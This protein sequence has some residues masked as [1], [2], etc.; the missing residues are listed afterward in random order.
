MGRDN[1]GAGLTTLLVSGP[2]QDGDTPFGFTKAGDGHLILAGDNTYGG[3]TRITDGTVL[4]R[5]SNAFGS[6]TGGTLVEGPA[7]IELDGD[8]AVPEPLTLANNAPD[9]AVRALVGTNTWS[10]PVTSS[11]ASPLRALNTSSLTFTGGVTAPSG[12]TLVPDPNAEI[13]ISGAPLTA[14]ASSKI[15]AQG[16]GTVAFGASD[17][18][19]G[20]LEIAST[21]VR[22]DAPNA[23]PPR[24]VV[25]MG[26]TGA[27]DAVLDLNGFDQTVAQLKRGL[28]TPGN[29]IVTS[30]TPATLTVD[31]SGSTMYFD[32]VFNGA[33]N[34]TKTGSGT[35]PDRRRPWNQR[36][37]NISNGTLRF[38]ATPVI[39][40]TARPASVRR[41]PTPPTAS[42]LSASCSNGGRKWQGTWGSSSSPPTTKT[43]RTLGLRHGIGSVRQQHSRDGGAST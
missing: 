7:W 3:T 31:H 42:K 18:L 34:V 8:L 1:N 41:Q 23:L 21:T 2:V 13:A 9:G 24:S 16:G 39:A 29:R 19:W 10:G 27:L 32:G 5:H 20:T 28:T 40:D 6:A 22:T 33:V 25:A 4:V 43:I 15:I 35:R 38:Y 36:R 26:R 11:A 37:L 12:L 14:G 17:N 30:A